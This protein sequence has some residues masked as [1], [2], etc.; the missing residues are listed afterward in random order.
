MAW[1]VAGSLQQLLL[2]L[3]NLAPRRNKA[4]DGSIGDAEH[5]S[6][7]SDHNPWYRRTVTA[8]DFTHDPRGGLDCNWLAQALINSGDPR[9]K[10]IIWNKRIWERSTGWK[11]YHGI[12]P[13]THHLHLSV[14]ANPSC[15]SKA[16]WNLGRST[17]P[18]VPPSNVLRK[19][20]KGDR[21]R[22]LQVKLNIHADGDFGS[23]TEAA[24]KE[25]QRKN[26]LEAD[27]V[28]GPATWAK[29]NAVSAPPPAAPIARPTL[30]KGDKGAG[31]SLVQQKLGI[32]VDGDFG[33]AT[34]RAVKAFQ[35]KRGMTAD[36][37]VGRQTYT[38]LGLGW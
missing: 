28:V 22:E 16:P 38:A 24:V 2:Q 3:N 32:K 14:E 5:A 7:S 31:V 15:E 8:R 26:G 19:G 29:I 27:G 34:E 18:T 1:H 33:P 6:R 23:T 10:Y 4:S 35:V 20:D 17:V 36:G 30:R 21:V 12:N 25:F 9:I 13:H 11:A 37:V